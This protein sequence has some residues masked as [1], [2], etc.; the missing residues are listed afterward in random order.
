M[1]LK[2]YGGPRWN[3]WNHFT[4]HLSVNHVWSPSQHWPSD[5]EVKSLKSLWRK[6]VLR[7]ENEKLGLCLIPGLQRRARIRFNIRFS[8][9]SSAV[10][11]SVWDATA[12]Y[13]QTS[14]FSCAGFGSTDFL[15]WR[16]ERK[17]SAPLEPKLPMQAI[18]RVRATKELRRDSLQWPRAQNR[19]GRHRESYTDVEERPGF[20][21]ASQW[22]RTYLEGQ[23]TSFFISLWHRLRD[24]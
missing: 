21:K 6:H 2:E 16:A 24:Q 7:V 13:Q 5:L 1:N 8:R 3:W 19:S 20:S 15:K 23:K 22:G 14:I 10:H 18:R 17:A 12:I 11:I 9:R 4:S